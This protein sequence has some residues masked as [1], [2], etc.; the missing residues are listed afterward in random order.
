MTAPPFPASRRSLVCLLA[1]QTQVAFN[2]NAAKLM[3]LA[4][5]QFPGVLPAQRV[6]LIVTL[7]PTLLV[8]P[9]IAFSPVAGWVSDRFSKW[10]VINFALFLQ[11]VLMAGVAAALWAHSLKASCVIF[12]L[13]ALQATIFAPAKRGIL[14]ELVGSEK[15]G[16]AVGWME[17]LGVAAILGGGFAGGQMFDHWTKLSGGDPWHGALIVSM[18]LTFLAALGWLFG[19]GVV[20]TAPQSAEPYSGGLWFRHAD[21]LGELWRSKP[22]FRAGLGVT[23]FYLL[24]GMLYLIVVEI[25]REMYGGD[26][27]SSSSSGFWLLLMG[28]GTVAGTLTAGAICRRSIELGLIPLASIGLAAGLMVLGCAV[29]RSPW[30][31]TGLVG[32]GFSGG[33]FLVP[34]YAYLQDKA[35]S[36][37][38]GRIL[39]GVGLAAG[40]IDDRIFVAIVVMALVTSIMA[41]PMMNWLLS[42]R[43]AEARE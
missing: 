34:L 40:V 2:D 17:M 14:K 26:I 43:I 36:A 27:G 23:W 41:G 29:P 10:W 38:R 20:R 3:L 32:I 6:E 42:D 37:R 22:L 30:F 25:G 8:L 1:A 28:L 5:A 19:Q 16:S 7:L 33:I 21:Q 35:G 9:F 4:L 18:V 15:L 31:Y 39:A 13:L 11:V 24:G 12:F